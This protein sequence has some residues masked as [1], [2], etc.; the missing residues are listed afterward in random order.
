MNS[1]QVSSVSIAKPTIYTARDFGVALPEPNIRQ[2]KQTAIKQKVGDFYP[3][4]Q[5]IIDT[6]IAVALVRPHHRVL[7]PSAGSGDL[8]QAIASIGVSNLNCFEINQQLQK[9]LKFQGFNLIGADFLASTPQ[10]I[11]D[12]IIANHPFSNNGVANHTQHALKFLNPE[13]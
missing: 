13:G 5:N 1:S 6:M 10:P 4:P 8:A 2:I 3:T 9:A 12:R 7:E 11:Y